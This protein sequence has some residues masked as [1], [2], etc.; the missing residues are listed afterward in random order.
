MIHC[1]KMFSQLLLFQLHFRHLTSTFMCPMDIGRFPMDTQM[2]PI[3]MECFGH[4]MDTIYFNWLDY[5]VDFDTATRFLS[6]LYL[7][8][9]Q[10]WDKMNKII[11]IHSVHK[12]PTDWPNRAHNRCYNGKPLS[13]SL[14]KDYSLVKS[15]ITNCHWFSDCWSSPWRISYCTTAHRITQLQRILVLRFVWFWGENWACT[16]CRYDTLVYV[17]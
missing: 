12:I 2:C 5:P 15:K 11:L 13:V 3:I 6:Y 16:F 1:I 8:L 14:L 9:H 10:N 7:S 17:V 4:T